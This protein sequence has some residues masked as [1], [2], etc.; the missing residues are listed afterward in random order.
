MSDQPMDDVDQA[1]IV[2]LG[3]QADRT[4]QPGGKP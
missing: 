3:A 4:A 1:T 2:E